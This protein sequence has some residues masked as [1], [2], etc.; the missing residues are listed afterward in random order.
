M[1]SKSEMMN[2]DHICKY[3]LPFKRN[4]Y[5][6]TGQWDI[7]VLQKFF[8]DGDNI[9]VNNTPMHTTFFFNFQTTTTTKVIWTL[10]TEGSSK[11]S[12]A[13]HARLTAI[14]A[15]GVLRHFPNK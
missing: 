4:L 14:T 11:H 15:P 6:C 2:V 9:R 12:I 5:V 10:Q 13:G 1:S 8:S 3:C 7:M